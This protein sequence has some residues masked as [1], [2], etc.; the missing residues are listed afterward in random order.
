MCGTPGRLLPL[1]AGHPG[2]VGIGQPGPVI[3]LGVRGVVRQ[4]HD[5]LVAV[6]EADHLEHRVDRPDRLGPDHAGPC[7]RSSGTCLTL[8]S[9]PRIA[10][11]RCDL[12]DL[13]LP[14]PEVRDRPR[15]FRRDAHRRGRPRDHLAVERRVEDLAVDPVLRRAGGRS[16][17]R[18]TARRAGAACARRRVG[19]RVPAASARAWRNSTCPSLAIPIQST[20]QSTT[21]CPSAHEDHPRQ[22][23][24]DGSTPLVGS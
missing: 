1:V 17:N 24:A 8:P 3:A 9:G 20:A 16:R 12:F 11:V 22:A 4:R 10:P 7:R 18:R 2:E 23:R 19:D 15:C 5:R 14:Q 13:G 6:P 21:G